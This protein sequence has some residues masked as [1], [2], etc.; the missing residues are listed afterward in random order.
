MKKL[1]LIALGLG[2]VMG[3]ASVPAQGP[4]TVKIWTHMVAQSPSIR[5]ELDVFEKNNPNIKVELT[6][7]VGAQYQQ[8]I[9]L[10]FKSNNSPDI[11]ST[12]LGEGDAWKKAV[13]DSKWALPLDKWATKEWQAGF[14]KGTFADGTNIFDGKVYSAPWDG[15]QQCCFYMFVNV[16]VFK[17][18]GLVDSKGNVLTPKTWTEERRFAKQIVEKT[19]GKTY[20]LGF[21]AKQGEFALGSIA[22]GT[23]WSGAT[24]DWITNCLDYSKGRY[25]YDNLAFAQWFGH[26]IDMREDGSIFPQSVAVDDEQARVLFAEG[27]FGM[28]IN[29]VWSPG[30]WKST[31]PTF[32]EGTDYIAIPVPNAT[33]K[34]RSFMHTSGASAAYAISS[35]TK[36]AEAAWKVFSFLHGKESAVRYAGYGE[37]LRVYPESAKAMDGVAAQMAQIG[38]DDVKIPPTFT[39]IRPQIA[40]VKT[41][42]VNKGLAYH[43]L[44]AASGQLKR[45]DIR[46][47]LKQVNDDYNAELKR[48]VEAAAKAGVKVS[49]ADFQFSKWTPNEDM[50]TEELTA[51]SK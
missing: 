40:D 1:M 5:K 27:K 49:V 29:G 18:A 42:P 6:P 35:Q 48:A 37:G 20:G 34:R 39:R 33:G 9:S 17:A 8:Q 41:N 15:F 50:T 30:S 24:C 13:T 25:A 43:I 21:G 38:T 7:L 46:A 2:T 22:T 36:N 3:T 28:Y 47:A 32:K 16:K 23:L 14:P 10:A 19:G 26:F 12:A 44:A 31:N 4:V 11:F 45:I 51:L